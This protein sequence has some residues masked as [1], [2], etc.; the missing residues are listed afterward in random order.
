[1]KTKK[2]VNMSVKVNTRIHEDTQN[3]G[4]QDRVQNSK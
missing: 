4:H 1:M 3:N 2:N